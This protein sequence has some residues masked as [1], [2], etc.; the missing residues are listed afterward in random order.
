[1]VSGCPGSDTWM[2]HGEV[3][4]TGRTTVD[5]IHDAPAATVRE[6]SPTMRERMPPATRMT[7]RY[8]TARPSRLP[9]VNETLTGRPASAV[10]GKAAGWSKNS[11]V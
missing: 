7:Y 10:A 1:M 6:A 3:R 9:T 11:T 4:H 8:P 5:T 2:R